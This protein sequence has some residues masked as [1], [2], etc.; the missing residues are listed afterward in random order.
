[1]KH[2]ADDVRVQYFRTSIMT[3]YVA[4][5]IPVIVMKVERYAIYSRQVRL[6][7]CAHKQYVDDVD[8]GTLGPT[9]I[10]DK[11]RVRRWARHRLS[12]LGKIQA[13]RRGLVGCA[14]RPT[15]IFLVARSWRSTLLLYGR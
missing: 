5:L 13:L 8:I 15:A 14:G 7:A 3:M 6:R 10:H 2:A 11:E 4:R 1:M 12:D 9:K